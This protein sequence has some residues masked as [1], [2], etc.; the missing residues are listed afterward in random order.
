MHE[1]SQRR[2]LASSRVYLTSY[3]YGRLRCLSESLQPDSS[4]KY[5][6]MQLVRLVYVDMNEAVI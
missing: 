3:S 5:T 1:V 6:E 2:R 4:I